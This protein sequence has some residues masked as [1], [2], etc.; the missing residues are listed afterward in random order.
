MFQ[1][2]QEVT[3]GEAGLYPALS[4]TGVKVMSIRLLLEEETDVVSWHSSVLAGVLQQLWGNVIWDQ[5]DCLLID[6]PPGSGDVSLAALERLPL[7][8][9]IVVSTP[10]A[11]VNEA[12][13][14]TMRLVGEHEVSVLGMIENFS[15]FF[16]GE[17][18]TELAG[19]YG[20]P[21]LDRLAF[22]S[23]LSVGA[24]LG[25]LE[26]LGNIYL[27]NSVAVIENL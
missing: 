4:E 8:G 27:P 21:I 10:Q 17:A 16:A 19:H 6:L 9:V 20:V 7:D 18:A 11:L 1:L 23:A 24:D 2:P 26:T 5:L 12:V 15:G 3:K 13:E 14:R 25:R 22:D